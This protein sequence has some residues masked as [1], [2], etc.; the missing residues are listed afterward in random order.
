MSVPAVV[1]R[2]I[3]PE[4]ATAFLARDPV[5]TVELL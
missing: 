3:T 5:A 4:Q 2:N 1:A